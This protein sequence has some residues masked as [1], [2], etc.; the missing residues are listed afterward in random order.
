MSSMRGA[1]RKTIGFFLA[2]LPLT[3]LAAFAPAHGQT[4]PY[5]TI[6]QAAA[7]SA[8][9]VEKLRGNVSMLQGSGGNIG[10]LSGAEGFLLVD[11]GI[12]VSQGKILGALAQLGPG[13][14]RYAITTHWHWDHADGNSWVR[15]AGATVIA[16]T[17]AVRRLKQTIRV[18]EWQH[19]FT[20]TAP[21]ALPSALIEKP[22]TI[23]FNGEEVQITP[24]AGPGHTD[25][26]LSVYFTKADILQVGDTF[27]N[28]QYPFLDYA[29]GGGI[30]PAIRAAERN[31]AMARETTIVV[32]GHGPIAGRK[33]LI[34]FRDMLVTVR[35]RV[36]R[37]K[38]EGLS[39][40]EVLATR[41]TK[42]FDARWGNSII[43]GELFT[44][45]VYRGV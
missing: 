18:A 29:G 7:Q 40:E 6:N 4:T 12:A 44:T 42:D 22:R 43:S 5:D 17:Q 38:A 45:L 14:P 2:G 21:D 41:P 3:A 23:R 11:A 31:V 15:A 13:K 34:T 24:Y 35:R 20:P 9:T 28:G 10:V 1:S 27:W 16:H 8:V 36:S 25:G 39:L 30:D 19:T 32:P 33:D 37:L 26:D